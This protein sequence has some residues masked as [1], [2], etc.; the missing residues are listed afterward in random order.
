MAGGQGHNTETGRKGFQ[1]VSLPA[2]RRPSAPAPGAR[3]AVVRMVL[4]DGFEYRTVVTGVLHRDPADGPARAW[5][6]DLAAGGH[7]AYMEHGVNHR[8]SVDGPAHRWNGGVE[9]GGGEAYIEHGDLH[10][11]PRQGPAR[12][13]CLRDHPEVVSEQ[14]WVRSKVFPSQA[15]AIAGWDAMNDSDGHEGD[16]HGR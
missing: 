5:G 9:H 12:R 2:A 11:D 4:P 10:R 15:E 8:P 16:G 7:E 1:R 3:T 14:Y 6:G 13:F